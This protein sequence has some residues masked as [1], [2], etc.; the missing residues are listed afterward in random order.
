VLSAAHIALL[1]AAANVLRGVS[2][3]IRSGTTAES[4]IADLAAFSTA[5]EAVQERETGTERVVP[6]SELFYTDGGA[7]VVE[8]SQ[9]PPTTP[10]ERFRLE[11]VSQGEHLRR[12]VADARAAR[13]DLARERVRRGLRHALRS[14]RQSAD[15]F[16]EHTVVDFL[17]AH[18]EAAL[19]LDA[20]TLGELD[21]I[22][23]QLA[24]PGSGPVSAP[25]RADATPVSS[26]A[27][28][29]ATRRTVERMD[30]LKTAPMSMTPVR[31]SSTVPPPSSAPQERV[32]PA[33]A[34]LVD[35]AAGVVSHVAT[36]AAK[37]GELL[38]AGIRNLGSLQTNPL[39][40]PTPLS[41]QPPV[42]IDVLLYRGRSA[43][44]RCREIREDARRSGR[45]VEG[46]ALDELYDLLDLA[47][48]T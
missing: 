29:S 24:R 2:T 18:S 42:P 13:D 38:D 32:A 36:G 10:P 26:P 21:A 20:R 43:I 40:A 44:E 5:L 15:S 33:V 12:L 25:R 14:L 27:H 47:L 1:R 3:S 22:A 30:E 17:E 4:Q 45:P 11:S 48:T 6:I 37:L 39:S 19:E 35:V 34:Q 31:P 7:T 9:T 46:E 28:A 23:D 8:A 16:G 41:E